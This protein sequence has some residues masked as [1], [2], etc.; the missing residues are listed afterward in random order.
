MTA[1]KEHSL[2]VMTYGQDPPYY[3][4]RCACGL[5]GHGEAPAGTSQE[6]IAGRARHDHDASVSS[7][8]AAKDGDGR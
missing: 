2:A 8:L 6:D 4:W 3:A 7:L 1:T 5:S